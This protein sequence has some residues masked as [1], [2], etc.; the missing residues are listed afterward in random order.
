[1]PVTDFKDLLL[2]RTIEGFDVQFDKEWDPTIKVYVI[3]DN[4]SDESFVE[5]CLLSKQPLSF[6]L[7]RTNKLGPGGARNEAIKLINE[8]PNKIDY[9]AYCDYDDVWDPGYLRESIKFLEDSKADMVYSDCKFINEKGGAMFPYGF[10]EID[11][12]SRDALKKSNYI[13]VSTVVH[14]TICAKNGFSV[15]CDP[16]DDWNN[17]LMISESFKIVHRKKQSV[18][19]LVKEKTYHNKTDNA[20][21]EA[22]VRAKHISSKPEIV[23]FTI[24]TNRE[25][26]S[27][28]SQKK[29]LLAPYSH[30][31]LSGKPNPK[32]YP[33][34][35]EVVSALKSECYITQIGVSGE[36][37]I[38]GADKIELDRSFDDLKKML[39]ECDIFVSVDSFFPHFAKYN[40]RSGGI[41]IF[42]LSDPEI[43]G[44]PDNINVLK[45]RQFLRRG[46]FMK[47]DDASYDVHSFV[48]P[49]IIVSKIKQA[50]RIT[51]S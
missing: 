42:S 22:R 25:V 15:D 13:W 35:S 1:M 18:T 12:F 2:K 21:A 14:K 3:N 31:M 20:I 9:I 47:W 46:Q 26:K 43:F 10:Q 45:D 24:D 39:D 37:K 16:L 32:N 11:E 34:F 50:L 30:K 41:V 38:P 5:F 48:S 17:W 51:A 40:N 6:E 28:S 49:D 29:I 36:A 7:I 23:Q 4:N 33:F 8:D 19:Y 27:I 44:Y